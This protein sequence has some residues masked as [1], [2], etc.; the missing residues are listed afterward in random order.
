[1][2]LYKSTDHMLD[3]L[4]GVGGPAPEA[5]LSKVNLIR[6]DRDKNITD[7]QRVNIGEFL[8]KGEAKYNIALLPGDV[9]YVPTRSQKFSIQDVFSVLQGV[10]LMNTGARVLTK[11]FGH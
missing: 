4:N 3:A 2:Y 9:L 1:M 5:D 6:I 7:M 10:N 8:K 11:G